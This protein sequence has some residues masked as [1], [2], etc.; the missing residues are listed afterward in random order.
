MVLAD[1]GTC[2]IFLIAAYPRSSQQ[3]SLAEG[4]ID[5]SP[6]VNG[7][8]AL[9]IRSATKYNAFSAFTFT[10]VV[11]LSKVFCP[12]CCCFLTSKYSSGLCFNPECLVSQ[13]RRSFEGF[14]ASL[15]SRLPHIMQSGLRAWWAFSSSEKEVSDFYSFL[16]LWVKFWLSSGPGN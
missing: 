16:H 7:C 4:K 6:I 8:L 9:A 5:S 11:A 13:W 1:R 3:M 15:D 10:D 2:A 14:I 12:S